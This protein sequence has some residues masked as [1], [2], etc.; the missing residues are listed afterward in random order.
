MPARAREMTSSPDSPERQA[1][2][3][4]AAGRRLPARGHLLKGMRRGPDLLV[5]DGVAPE[6]VDLGDPRQLDEYDA[7]RAALHHS[8]LRLGVGDLVQVAA[9]VEHREVVDRG[10]RTL[11][12]HR[13]PGLME[14]FQFGVLHARA[15]ILMS[16]RSASHLLDEDPYDSGGG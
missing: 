4:V 8:S 15:S 2:S 1:A 10:E 12:K 11:A 7:G 6:P 9:G 13:L 5:S 3:I 16:R 14:D